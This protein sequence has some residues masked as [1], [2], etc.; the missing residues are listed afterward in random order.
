MVDLILK[1][2]KIITCI[3][4]KDLADFNMKSRSKFIDTI[5]RSEERVLN[6]PKEIFDTLSEV[7]KIGNCS[8]RR[9]ERR[10]LLNSSE[11]EMAY[12]KRL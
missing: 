4:I 8:Y 11:I 10:I 6:I 12:N 9:V 1:S 7:E 3:D 5:I 2:G